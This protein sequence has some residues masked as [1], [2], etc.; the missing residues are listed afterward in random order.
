MSDTVTAKINA[1]VRTPSAVYIPKTHHP[2]VKSRLRA[3]G[4]EM[5][6][7]LRI[8]LRLAERVDLPLFDGAKVVYQSQGL[9]LVRMNFTPR[10]EDWVRLGQ[11]ALSMGVSR[12]WLF[13]WLFRREAG[14]SG[15][16]LS[17][18]GCTSFW[19]NR[20]I[21]AF[22]VLDMVTTVLIRGRRPA[23]PG[24]HDPSRREPGTREPA[25][26]GPSKPMKVSE[27]SRLWL[28]RLRRAMRPPSPAPA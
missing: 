20:A 17:G 5:P 16:N 6:D 24:T 4:I 11:L 23:H 18:A 8:L 28:T 27:E 26:R 14:S 7:Y 9:E 21:E 15:A 12:A 13:V 2:S 10:N 3:L 1:Q 25:A 22:V 19:R